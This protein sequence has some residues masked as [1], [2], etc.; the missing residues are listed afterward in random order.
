MNK[1]YFIITTLAVI[2]TAAALWPGIVVKHY[3]DESGKIDSEI[4]LAV[5]SDLHSG[6]YGENQKQLLGVL[7]RQNPDVILLTGDIAD[8]HVSHDGTRQLLEVLGEMFPCFYVS[9]NHEFWSGEADYIKDMI[10]SFGV[11]VLEG[12]CEIIEIQGQKLRI[13]GVDDPERFDAN[14]YTEDGWKNQFNNCRAETGDGIYSVLLSHRPELADLYNNSGFDL[15]AAGHAHGGQVRIPFVLNG[16]L[17]P[18][19]GFFPKYAGGKYILGNT[20]MVVSRGLGRNRIPRIFNPVE[21]VIINLRPE[22]Q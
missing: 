3:T 16:L 2:I 17:A 20:V 4:K 8:D 12:E 10:R 14:V 13:C 9:G 18:N 5:I 7:H 11:K 22:L 6:I 21:V 19:Q 15:V 1:K